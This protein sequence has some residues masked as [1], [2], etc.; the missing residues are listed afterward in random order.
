MATTE[1]IFNDAVALPPD[2]RADLTERLVASLLEDIS[3]RDYHCTASG[4]AS[5]HCSSRVWT[6]EADFGRCEVM[7][8]VQSLV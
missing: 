4:S 7:A 1:E 2:E 8:R 5:T 3:R 6:S